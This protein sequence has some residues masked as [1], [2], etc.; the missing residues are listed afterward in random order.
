LRKLRLI[1]SSFDSRTCTPC[2][3]AKKTE[4]A[5]QQSELKAEDILERIHSDISGPF[6]ESVKH[7]SI[8]NLLFLDEASRWAECFDIKDRASATVTAKFRE[9]L[10]AVERETGMKVKKLRID[11]GGEYKDHLTPLLTS[12]GIKVEATPPRTP[13]CDL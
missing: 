9:F 8:Y 10:A 6:V 1:Q 7:K 5:F 13:Q 11:G 12:L 2:L 4:R 3:R